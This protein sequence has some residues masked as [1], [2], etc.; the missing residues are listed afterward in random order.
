MKDL[1]LL[2]LPDLELVKP[3]LSPFEKQLL[4]SNVC[5]FSTN[6]LYPSLSNLPTDAKINLIICNESIFKGQLEKL[7]SPLTANKK[8]VYI[9]FHVDC[10]K[11][12]ILQKLYNEIES[13]KIQFP[14]V[15]DSYRTEG[16]AGQL[17]LQSGIACSNND[18]IAFYKAIK[19]Y[20]K[21]FQFDLHL[22]AGFHLTHHVL[23]TKKLKILLDQAFPQTTL[24]QKV[25]KLL[26]DPR[27]IE[28]LDSVDP[29]SSQSIHNQFFNL[30]KIIFFPQRID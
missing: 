6:R 19:S 1:I 9:N 21:K 22:E 29:K 18:Q 26:Q 17:L 27:I 11:S 20:R 16:P 14:I 24:E 10:K 7:L 25:S 3:F 23:E 4:N 2:F 5:G 13:Q 8:N 12:D 30:C 15:E 28:V